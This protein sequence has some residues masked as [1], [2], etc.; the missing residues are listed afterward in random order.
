M[1]DKNSKAVGD[2]VILEI[3]ERHQERNIDGIIIPLLGELNSKM[4]KGKIISIGPDAG[5]YNLKEG[6]VV[7]YDTMS[8]YNDTYP[9]V[10]T[11]IE[12]V[13]ARI[14]E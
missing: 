7:M 5:I 11:K 13:I 8:V 1:I 12:N 14:E 3:L 10:I 6:D 2:K 4:T 9:F